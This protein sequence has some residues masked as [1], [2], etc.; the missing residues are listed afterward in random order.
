MPWVSP[1]D[2]KVFNLGGTQDHISERAV[3]E[4][5][6]LAPPGTSL[7][8]VRGMILAH[9]F[10]VCVTQR[11][12]SFNQDVKAI[13][14]KRTTDG[15]F[16]AHWLNGHSDALLRHVTEATHGT[17]RIELTDLLKHTVLLPVFPE[18]QQVA[19][20]LD[21]LDNAIL[22]TEQL[23]AKLKQMKQ[24][25]LHDLLT[26]GID[27]NGE[28]RDPD[29]HPEQFKDSPLG[30]IPAK[31][32]TFLLGNMLAGIDSGKSPNCP[33]RPAAGDEWGVLKVSAVRPDGFRANENKVLTNAL[34]ANPAH[35]VRDGDLLIT[36]ANTYEL[37]GFSCLVRD[38]P[39]RLLLCDKTLRLRINQCAD[40]VCLFY[41]MQ[42]SYVRR[43]IE[44]SAT[45]SSGSMK[46]IS[47]SAVRALRIMVAPKDEQ[48]A[49]ASALRASDDRLTRESQ[50]AEKLRLF[51]QGLMDDLLTGRV[52]VT[53]L[54]AEP[55][56]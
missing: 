6:R 13:V 47:Q 4:G 52:R 12:M 50:N 55:A 25:L 49:L 41:M 30:R 1:K 42:M 14:P 35:E 51:K 10:P 48:V 28:L 18:Q 27:E 34:L 53:P 26:R 44:N 8:V 16:L 22:K 3:A 43:Q 39:P 37:V 2:M 29:R 11:A 24:G 45:G 21:T 15:R 56:P 54:L 46:N 31:W 33:D 38:P 5:A 17:K 32:D 19:E 9:T 40:R 36:R 20:I 23:I 7:I